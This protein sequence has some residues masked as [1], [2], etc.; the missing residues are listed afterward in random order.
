MKAEAPHGKVEKHDDLIWFTSTSVDK[1]TS[2]EKPKQDHYRGRQPQRDQRQTRRSRSLSQNPRGPPRNNYVN[3]QMSNKN[4][5]IPD[6]GFQRFPR[7][8]CE[9][10]GLPGHEMKVCWRYQGCCVRCGS[11]YHYARDCPEPRRNFEPPRPSRR[12]HNNYRGGHQPQ[13]NPS[14]DSSFLRSRSNDRE[15]YLRTAPLNPNSPSWAP[16]TNHIEV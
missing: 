4:P 14:R 11:T 3:S 10:C 1:Q 9:F 15:N 7:P 2:N 16:N 13:Y 12:G 6:R 8:I 5:W